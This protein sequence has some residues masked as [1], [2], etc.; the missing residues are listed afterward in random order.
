MNALRDRGLHNVGLRFRSHA[1]DGVLSPER[2]VFSFKGLEEAP[3]ELDE[4]EEESEQHAFPREGQF[5]AQ[6]HEEDKEQLQRVTDR[7]QKGGQV[8]VQQLDQHSRGSSIEA[9]VRL[10]DKEN[11]MNTPARREE[12]G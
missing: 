9:Q 12:G 6:R 2:D 10:N 7:R 5:D 1:S 11:A 8:L 4:R 3:E